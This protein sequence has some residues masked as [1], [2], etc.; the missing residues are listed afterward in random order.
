MPKR[1]KT[2]PTEVKIQIAP[3][4]PLAEPSYQKQGSQTDSNTMLTEKHHD[5]TQQRQLQPLFE[6]QEMLNTNTPLYITENAVDNNDFDFY[7][8]QFLS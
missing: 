2:V 6:P 8:M 4:T 3:A 1:T 7:T 5:Y